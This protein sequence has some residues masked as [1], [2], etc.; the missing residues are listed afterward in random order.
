MPTRFFIRTLT[1]V[2]PPPQP[3]I[4]FSDNASLTWPLSSSSKSNPPLPSKIVSKNQRCSGESTSLPPMSPG[5]KFRLAS[6]MC[7]SFRWV[8]SLS[9]QVFRQVLRYSLPLKIKKKKL[10]KNGRRRTTMCCCPLPS[11]KS[12]FIRHCLLFILHYQA[13]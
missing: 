1:S 3:P 8:S 11:S 9:H 13:K 7:L 4:Y 12:L 10:A 5:F 2:P 6:H